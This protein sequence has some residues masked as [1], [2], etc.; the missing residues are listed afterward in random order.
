[1]NLFISSCPILQFLS[2]TTSSRQKVFFSRVVSQLFAT[3]FPL[4]SYEIVNSLK[5]LNWVEYWY[6]TRQEKRRD[7]C[8]YEIINST[9][10][11]Q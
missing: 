6:L 11:S 8:R 7:K 5:K 1:M 4:S 2:A 10:H 3:F 9:K